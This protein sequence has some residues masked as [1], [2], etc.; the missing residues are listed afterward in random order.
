MNE[1]GERKIHHKLLKIK[2]LKNDHRQENQNY[3]QKYVNKHQLFSEIY[4]TGLK[5]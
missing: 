1:L 2:Q 5:V 3:H 4:E